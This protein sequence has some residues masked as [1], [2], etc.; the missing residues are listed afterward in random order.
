MS[1]SFSVY[2]PGNSDNYEHSV[3]LTKAQHKSDHDH[4]H[5]DVNF[6]PA[7]RS[8]LPV[9]VYM[10]NITPSR[11]N[12]APCRDGMKASQKDRTGWKSHVNVDHFQNFSWLNL[13]PHLNFSRDF[14]ERVPSRGLKN[15]DEIVHKFLRC[16]YVTSM[17]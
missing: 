1:R 16:F 7:R 10:E 15:L 4:L 8:I 2:Q 9:S 13:S 17:T 6:N 11:R 5:I 14:F 3:S 12:I